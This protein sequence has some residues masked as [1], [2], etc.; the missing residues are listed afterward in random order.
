MNT[1]K[2]PSFNQYLMLALIGLG[3]WFPVVWTAL[4]YAVSSAAEPMTIGSAIVLLGQLEI[5]A[6]IFLL[7]YAF[8]FKPW[9]L[10]VA[11][12]VGFFLNVLGA[13]VAAVG[14]IV[15]LANL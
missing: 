2:K 12:R 1:A 6:I 9:R 14:I 7:I 3:I 13:A 10:S 8:C 15:G 11:L 5:F 4:A